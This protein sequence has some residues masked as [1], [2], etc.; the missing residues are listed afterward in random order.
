MYG[1]IQAITKHKDL[2]IKGAA[3]ARRRGTYQ[4]K[5]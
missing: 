5:Y 2:G 3:D 1:S 4:V